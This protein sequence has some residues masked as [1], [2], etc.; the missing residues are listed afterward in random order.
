MDYETITIVRKDAIATITMNRPE[1]KNSLTPQVIDELV[2]VTSELSR[3]Q[4]TIVVILT[5]AGEEAFC[6]GADL[7]AQAVD[8][9]TWGSGKILWYAR[10]IA[11][12]QLNLRHM[13]QPVIGAINGVAAGVGCTIAL[14]CDIRIASEKARFRPGFGNIALHPEGGITYLLPRLIGVSKALEILLTARI[15]DAEEAEALGLVRN[16]VSPQELLPA[17]KAL[18]SQIA[19]GPPIVNSLIKQSVYQGLDM[20]MIPA[21]DREGVINTLLFFSE[22]HQEGVNSLLEK[23]KPKFKGR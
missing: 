11:Q 3:D 13:P 22:D 18:A 15:I 16:I 2:H 9:E 19:E 4:E 17:A 20:D 10:S 1:N 6:V 5:G 7:K 8:G 12:V 21:T 23:R 14:A